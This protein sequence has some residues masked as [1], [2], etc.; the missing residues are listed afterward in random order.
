M[1]KNLGV[2]T[3]V[4]PQPVLIIGTYGEGGIPNAMNAAWGGICDSDKLFISLS[5]E[6][7]TVA[8]LKKTGAF[9]VSIGTASE[10]VAC[11]YVGIASGNRVKDKIERA[12][13]HVRRAPHVDAPLFDE[14][15]LAIECEVFSLNEEDGIL[16]GKIKNVSAD[17]SILTEGRVDPGKLRPISFDPENNAYLLV[18]EKVGNAFKDGLSLPK[19]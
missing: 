19:D 11:D 9:T 16:I 8:N 14:L 3:A 17:E 7:K 10:V 18:G 13:W 15:P 5:L 12:H 1:R 6:H 2:K 4:Y